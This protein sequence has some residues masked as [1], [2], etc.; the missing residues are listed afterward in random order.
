MPKYREFKGSIPGQLETRFCHKDQQGWIVSALGNNS[1][2]IKCRQRT[3]Q[4]GSF[5]SDGRL[6]LAVAE[7]ELAAAKADWKLKFNA[8]NPKPK[9]KTKIR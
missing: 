3:E 6:T 1:R 4:T 5:H 9:R 7:E 8:D 2:C